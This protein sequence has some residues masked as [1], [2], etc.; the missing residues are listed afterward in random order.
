MHALSSKH[1]YMHAHARTHARASPIFRV[2]CNA[3]PCYSGNLSFMHVANVL[4]KAQH[5]MLSVFGIE[6]VALE[7]PESSSKSGVQWVCMNKQSAKMHDC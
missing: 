2:A 4:P 1:A 3:S 7:R 6:M 5:R